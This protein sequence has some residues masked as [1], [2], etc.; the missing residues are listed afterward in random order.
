[1]NRKLIP[2][3]AG[4]V[5]PR[6]AEREEGRATALVFWLWTFSATARQAPNWAKLAAEAMG[7]QVLRPVW[8]IMPA[9]MTLYMW[10]RPMTTVQ[11]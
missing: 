5:M 6:E 9:S 1:M 8:A 7:I 3:M 11:G 2:K 4:S 10:C